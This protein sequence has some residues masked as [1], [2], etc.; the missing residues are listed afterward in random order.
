M[1]VRIQ[2]G[3]REVIA[4]LCLLKLVIKNSR[5]LQLLIVDPLL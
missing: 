2:R 3:T 4:P 5:L 1:Q